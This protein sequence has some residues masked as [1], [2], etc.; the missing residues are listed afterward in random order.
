[1]QSFHRFAL[2]WTV[3]AVAILAAGQDAATQEPGAVSVAAGQDTGVDALRQCQHVCIRKRL[4]MSSLWACLKDPS[5]DVPH[6]VRKGPAGG[7]VKVAE[8]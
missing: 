6:N 8:G 4:N 5:H 1:M 2:T 3:A 7:W